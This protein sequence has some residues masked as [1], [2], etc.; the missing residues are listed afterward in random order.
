ME[1]EGVEDAVL[2]H[3]GTNYSF[4]QELL[5]GILKDAHPGD[6]LLL[7]G[8]TNMLEY[9]MN[10]AKNI[11]GMIVIFNAAPWPPQVSTCWRAQF[12][13]DWLIINAD[14]AMSILEKS[15]NPNC[16]EK[17]NIGTESALRSLMEHTSSSH[18]IVTL[19]GEGCRAL[20]NQGETLRYYACPAIKVK[21]IDTTGAGDSFTGYFIASLLLGRNHYGSMVSEATSKLDD[22]EFALALATAAAAI[23]VTRLGAFVS[24]PESQEVTEFL[25]QSLPELFP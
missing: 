7:Q 17:Y 13:I 25:I 2:L 1:D 5:E 4:T 22:V 20:L 18:V 23:C 15:D 10:Y 3:R 21:E 19:G 14:E 24:I 11:M 16:R 6:Y 12:P 9:A 8:E